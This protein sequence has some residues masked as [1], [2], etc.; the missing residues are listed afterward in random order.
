MA[1]SLPTLFAP[2]KRVPIRVIREQGVQLSRVPL[3]SEFLNAVPDVVL[4]L[5]SDRQA[6]FANQSLLDMIQGEW[7]QVEGK[8]PGEILD[9]V[10]A[11]NNHGGCGTTEFGRSCPAWVGGTTSK[12]AGSCGAAERRSI[13]G[14]Q[15]HRS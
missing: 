8:R 4:I 15:P 6:I 2:A 11:V 12:S 10:H 3:L 1:S 13:C 9:C 5:N 14:C 7:V